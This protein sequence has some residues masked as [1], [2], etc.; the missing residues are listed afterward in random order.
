MW[1]PASEALGRKP[2]FVGAMLLCTLFQLGG[3][4][5]DANAAAMLTTRFGAGVAASAP[6]VLSG[7]VLADIWHPIERG[8][9]LA[10]WGVRCVTTHP[11]HAE[12]CSVF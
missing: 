10:V 12:H 3:A 4:L 7:G 2:F 9:A 11:D 8:A 1:G 5:P 6:L